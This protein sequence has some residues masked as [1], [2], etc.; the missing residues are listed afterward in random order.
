[1]SLRAR[2][3]HFVVLGAV[4]FTLTI[5]AH[6]TQTL[7][8]VAPSVSVTTRSNDLGTPLAA[9]QTRVSNASRAIGAHEKSGGYKIVALVFCE[10]HRHARRRKTADKVQ[11]GGHVML[12]SLTAIYARI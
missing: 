8:H 1:M 11:M 4:L 6:L 3:L 2:K 9:S 7:L 10:F 12:T 5:L